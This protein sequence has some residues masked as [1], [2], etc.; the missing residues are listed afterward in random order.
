[1]HAYVDDSGDGG[2]KIYKGS[3]RY[4]VVA[5]VVFQ[6][7]A[8][9]AS[10]DCKI[11]ALRDDL[12]LHP[13]FE[14]KFNSCRRDIRERFLRAVCP[15]EFFYCGT[16]ID[17]GNI[18]GL[19]EQGVADKTS[20]YRGAVTLGLADFREFLGQAVVTIDGDGER[21]F[22]RMLGSS[23]KQQMND[24]DKCAIRTV[25]VGRSSGSNL[26][27]LADMVVG[28]LKRSFGSKADAG[29]YRAIIR[30]KEKAIRLWPK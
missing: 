14:F 23:L 11:K 1:M 25:R 5:L 16:V 21:D 7:D 12:G 8:E 24:L 15:C 27:Q 4:F 19:R 28:A 26:L 9:V 3:S 10:C 30:H 18:D 6:N 2:L 13:L 20:V 22:V 17:K 29:V